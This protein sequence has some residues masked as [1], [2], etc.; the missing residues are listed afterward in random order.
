MK[1]EILDVYE[2]PEAEEVKLVVEPTCTSNCPLDSTED[3]EPIDP[4]CPN[5]EF[6][7]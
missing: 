7:M 1:K 3:P 4:D 6:V 2:R 5:K